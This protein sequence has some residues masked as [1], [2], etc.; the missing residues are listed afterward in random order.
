MRELCNCLRKILKHQNIHNQS[1]E[2][3]LWWNPCPLYI[4]GQLTI[5][6]QWQHDTAVS[7][8]SGMITSA[9]PLCLNRDANPG[10]MFV[11]ATIWLLKYSVEL[12]G[13]LDVLTWC[14]THLCYSILLNANR[15]HC[16]LVA[17]SES[18]F[19]IRVPDLMWPGFALN[20]VIICIS[21]TITSSSTIHRELLKILRHTSFSP[22][23]PTA[24]SICPAPLG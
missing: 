6:N 18:S 1:L 9:H 24:S 17:A 16:G 3:F 20:Q 5:K 21:Y 11:S 7:L 10:W 13:L 14:C 8:L 23:S 15:L 12:N 22:S 19:C 2:L 4:R